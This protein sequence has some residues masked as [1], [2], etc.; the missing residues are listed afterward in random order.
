VGVNTFA[1]RVGASELLVNPGGDI[2]KNFA[3]NGEQAIKYSQQ[4][5]RSDCAPWQSNYL[6]TKLKRRGLINC[7]Y[8]PELEKFPYYDDASV[9]L[10]ALR[11]FISAFVD[12]YYP[13]DDAITTDNELLGWFDEAANVASIVDF[14]DSIST[15][16]ELVAVLSHL[17]YLISILHGSLNSNSLVHYSAVLPMHPLSLNQPLPKEK[18]V[19][20]LVPFLPNLEASIQHIALVASFNQAQ[21]ADTPDSLRFLFNEPEFQAHI[22]KEV[23]AA[24]KAYSST[25]SR[26]SKE[27]KGRKLDSN[28]YSQG[29]PFV[30]DVF[31]PAKAPGILAA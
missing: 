28:G 2:E 20:S 26:F 30:W 31:D 17:A 22:N 14:P 5:W 24:A 3:W 21:I 9:I 15:K 18:G 19:S 25:L 12:A 13:S 27:V 16:S 10:G 4:I 1:Y 23:R 11:T 7:N 29:M 8:G 6:E